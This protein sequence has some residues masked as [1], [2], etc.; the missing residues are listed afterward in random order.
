MV[1]I[2][3]YAICRLVMIPIYC[4]YAFSPGSVFAQDREVKVTLHIKQ[5]SVNNILSKVKEQTGLSPTYSGTAK[6]D[7][8]KEADLIAA[9]EKV[10]SVLEKLLTPRGYT[11]EIS[12]WYIIITKGVPAAAARKISSTDS[13]TAVRQLAGTV[14]DADGKPV[15]GANITVKGTKPK[16][17]TNTEGKFVLGRVRENDTLIVYMLGFELQEVATGRKSRVNIT[18]H[19]VVSF[20]DETVVW[21]IGAAS[22]RFT[23]GNISVI[24]AKD[25]VNQPISNPLLALQ[26]RVPGLLIEQVT[27][28]PG[29]GVKV[30]LQGQNS[31]SRGNDPL[32]IVDGIPFLPR[33]PYTLSAI[34]GGSGSNGVNVA[35]TEA[36]AGNP[37][38]LINP[39]DIDSI[40]VLKDVN[41]VVIYG[42]RA[43]NGAIVITTKRG[44]AKPF[45]IDITL[46]NGWGMVTR[47][48]QLLSTSQYLAMRATAYRNDG[49]PVPDRSTAHTQDNL[50]LT[51]YDPARYTDWQKVLIG[52][53]AQYRNLYADVSGGKKNTHYQAGIGYRRQT[54]VF[55]GE[56]GD[57]K[58]SLHVGFV[59]GS[60]STKFKLTITGNYT[61]SNTALIADDFTRDAI[62]LAPNAPALYGQ[63]GSLN[64]DT[65]PNG[66]AVW[67]NPLA[68][69]SRQYHN[70]ATN[71]LAGA[72]AGYKLPYGF[73]FSGALGYNRLQAN[74]ELLQPLSYYAPKARVYEQNKLQLA[75][76]R[77]QTW[78][79]E[80][81]L[82]YHKEAGN[83][84]YTATIGYSWQ[85]QTAGRVATEGSGFERDEQVPDLS[86]ASQRSTSSTDAYYRF[87]AIYGTLRR[88]WDNRY[89][90]SLSIRQDHSSRIE[91]AARSHIFGSAA[92]AWIFLDKAAGRG[93]LPLLSFG[94]LKAGYCATGND[95]V[96]ADDPYKYNT[97]LYRPLLPQWEQIRK[98]SLGMDLGAL[99]DRLSVG[100]NYYH[101]RSANQLLYNADPTAVGFPR[102][103]RSYNALVQNRGWEFELHTA[104]IKIGECMW[105]ADAT[106]TIPQSKLLTFNGLENT[107]YVRDF[108]VGQPLNIVR[109]YASAGV[110]PETGLNRI[111]DRNGK[112]LSPGVLGTPEDL[113]VN[114]RLA[115]RY[116][117]GFHNRFTYRDLELD[118]AF[119]FVSQM[120]PLYNWGNQPGLFNGIANS[121]NQPVAVLNAWQKTGD[122]T[123][124]P[125]A[126][127]SLSDTTYASYINGVFSSAVYGDASYVRLKNLALSYTFHKK[128]NHPADIKVFVHAQNLF[129]FT[130]YKG[131]D[132]ETKSAVSL[133]PLKVITLGINFTLQGKS[134][135]NDATKKRDRS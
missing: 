10:E 37:L 120:G 87:S 9:N 83:G 38:D 101:N 6:R 67:T 33:F 8:N 60:D 102:S 59:Q 47:K 63:D 135:A 54:T 74:D 117:G 82:N 41:A 130:G 110:D 11:F 90:V 112:I 71:L 34:Q 77:M 49:L 26:G 75:T 127:S 45:K 84:T 70:I 132:P 124:I 93:S 122:I 100:I 91:K 92:A 12:D 134:S 30:Q 106:L 111:L 95:G 119:Q 24:K 25:I 15:A 81:Q 32:Y 57:R 2:S 46:E 4:L 50:D 27:G 98:L 43:A 40:T 68:Y 78:S 96:L 65:L 133:P 44:A 39:A 76:A 14:T 108:V 56:L 66:D 20:L 19:T 23:T 72:T 62:A 13:A 113:V 28:L 105:S 97:L 115:P 123:N 118:I 103:I 79:I 35:G 107:P 125:K 16:T 55:P 51:W 31:L 73:Y 69:L 53:I 88:N 5:Q 36:G 3:R 21:G 86:A 116:Y 80:P 131:L 128:G 29:T 85:E 22:Q 129:T 99:D 121:G 18:L 42:G 64:W 58:G 17:I 89:I 52:G 61:R 48:M 1:K 7:F 126:S 104:K 114:I 109:A 94:K